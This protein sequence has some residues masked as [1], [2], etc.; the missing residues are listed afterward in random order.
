MNNLK[1]SDMRQIELKLAN[2][3]TSYLDN[4]QDCAMYWKS[5]NM[6]IMINDDADE[7]IKELFDS[8]KNRCQNKLES[9][10]SLVSLSSITSIYCII[11]VIKKKNP[12]CGGSHIDSPDWIKNKK[13]AMNLINKKDNKFFQYAVTF[14]L[15][16]EKI[17]NKSWKN[18]KN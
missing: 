5:D 18:N 1:K 12:N 7:A 9:I 4:D 11:D 15:N 8:L 17:R 3:F 2:N 14:A 10:K 13:A 16:H 6:E